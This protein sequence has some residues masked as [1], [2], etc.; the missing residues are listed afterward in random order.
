[1]LVAELV[2][3]QDLLRSNSDKPQ[4][5]IQIQQVYSEWWKGNMWKDRGWSRGSVC[6]FLASSLVVFVWTIG[7]AAGYFSGEMHGNVVYSLLSVFV[8]VVLFAA[9]VVFLSRGAEKAKKRDDKVS[10]EE[11]EDG[12]LA[13]FQRYLQQPMQRLLGSSQDSSPSTPSKRE[14]EWRG[15]VSFLQ[16][17]MNR[18]AT[19]SNSFAADQMKTMEQRLTTSESR[20]RSEVVS[21]EEN[22]SQFKHEIQRQLTE[23]EC[24]NQRMMQQI[25]SHLEAANDTGAQ[26]HDESPLRPRHIQ[27]SASR[28]QI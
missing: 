6:F 14:D 13:K 12:N 7:E 4:S 19:A 16:G 23:M 28:L 17:E 22:M 2:S 21:L 5:S 3:F 25:L 1:M 9:I 27:S 18:L 24:N 10:D 15:R 8:N 11:S 26:H 20:V